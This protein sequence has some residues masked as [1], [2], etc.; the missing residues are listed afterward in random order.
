[1]NAVFNR[2][3]RHVLAVAALAMAASAQA[4]NANAPRQ[5]LCK[6]ALPFVAKEFAS[7]LEPVRREGFCLEGDFNSDGKQD[8]FMVVKVLVE[9]VPAARIRTIHPFGFE[10]GGDKGRR[11]FLALHSTTSSQPSDWARY[12][13]LLLDGSNPVLV[14]RD[15]ETG[16][17]MERVGQGSQDV[18]ELRVPRRQ[19][20]GEGILIGTVA[21][22]AVL[23]W[24][25]KSYIFHED[26]AGP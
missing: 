3:F 5:A 7:V 19:M 10:K 12:E 20:R 14:L 9:K 25:G 17:D 4:A 8:L 11:Q 22:S 18:K 26:P 24:N 6:N 2:C 1:M 16:S 15:N 13:R 21:V 23:Y